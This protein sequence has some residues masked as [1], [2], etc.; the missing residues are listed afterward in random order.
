MDKQRI[1]I[2]LFDAKLTLE[3]RI[4]A[5]TG[6]LAK[7]DWRPTRAHIEGMRNAMSRALDGVT[8]ALAELE[9][10]EEKADG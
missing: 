7:T 1:E 6:A 8:K 9:K 3:H 5:A 10:E 4:T 2:E